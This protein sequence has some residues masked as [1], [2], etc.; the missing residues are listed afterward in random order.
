MALRAVIFDVGGVLLH[1]PNNRRQCQWETEFGLAEGAIDQALWATDLANQARLGH[2]QSD[3]VWRLLATHLHLTRDQIQRI[4][5]TY[6]VDEYLDPAMEQLLQDLRPHFQLALLT[7]A[8]S[9]A[10]STLTKKF[11]LST[12]VDDMII[13]AEVGFAKPDPAIYHLTLQRLGIEPKEALFIDDKVRNTVAAQRVGIASI[14]FQS[15]AQVI[16]EIQTYRMMRA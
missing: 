11:S 4:Q 13:S 14:V 3:D 2:I 1:L 7:N 9:D 5:Q 16:E 6:F 12:M 10:R 15:S 8:W